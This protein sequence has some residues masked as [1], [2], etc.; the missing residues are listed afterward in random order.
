MLD[1]RGV[2]RAIRAFRAGFRS[3]RMRGNPWRQGG[4]FVLGPHDHVRFEWRDRFMGDSP[5][6]DRVLEAIGAA[7]PVDPAVTRRRT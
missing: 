5:P 1:P 7:S 4:V 6:L 2:V 3:G